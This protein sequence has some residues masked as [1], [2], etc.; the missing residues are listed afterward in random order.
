MVVDSGLV[1]PHAGLVQGLV[2][3]LDQIVANDL[4][5]P[6]V[7]VLRAESGFGKSR[8]V[9]ELYGRL[10]VTTRTGL[11]AVDPGFWHRSG[12]PR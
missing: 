11:L 4:E 5:V 6:R 12:L 7:V 9:R 1:G 3:R 10:A 2:D 8:I